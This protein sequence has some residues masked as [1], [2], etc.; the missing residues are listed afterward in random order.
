[1]IASVSI[2]SALGGCQTT[3]SQAPL[4]QQA[5][6]DMFNQHGQASLDSRKYEKAALAF[7]KSLEIDPSNHEARLGFAD[8]LSKLKKYDH[9]LRNYQLLLAE[10]AYKA[11]ALQGIGLV[12]LQRGYLD[13]AKE[14]LRLAVD[15]DENLWR[16]WNGLAQIYAYEYNWE[17]TDRSYASALENSGGQQHVIYNNMGVSYLARGEQKNAI[18]AFDSALSYAPDL[19]VTQ[20]NYKLAL[21][22]QSRYD[23]ATIEDDVYEQAKALNNVGYAAML[24]G[25]YTEAERLLLQSIEVSPSFYKA[26]Y[27]NLQILYQIK[28]KG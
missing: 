12:E 26:P 18:E 10:D 28:G 19:D 5:S 24:Q 22:T 25:D 16:S 8:S 17:E 20:T 15:M 23:E 1:M 3:T 7:Q 2:A 6:P 21:A 14:S 13:T 27:H 9:A 4:V 11:H